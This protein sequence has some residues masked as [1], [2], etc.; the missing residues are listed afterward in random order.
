MALT[1]T[2]LVRGV[3]SAFQKAKRM[4]PA[5]KDR[6]EVRR[7]ALKLRFWG[8]RHTAVIGSE[9]VIDLN[10]EAIHAMK[11]MGVYELRLEDE[12][13]GHRNIRIV[14]FV[15]PSDWKQCEG[16][17]LPVIWVLEAIHKKRSDWTKFDIDRFRAIRAIVRERFYE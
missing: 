14:F 4:W 8:E 15:P 9:T 12:I 13:G 17:P 1:G 2:H 7:Q 11:G 3:R 5:T 6:M 10:Y 16:T